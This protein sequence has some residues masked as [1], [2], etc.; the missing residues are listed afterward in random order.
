MTHRLIRF[1][2]MRGLQRGVFGS[3]RNWLGVWVGLAA[4]RQVHKR[5]GREPELVDR[6]VLKPGQSVEIRDTGVKWK[7]AAP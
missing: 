7:D 3:S 5:L 1:L 4:A 6:V 2:R